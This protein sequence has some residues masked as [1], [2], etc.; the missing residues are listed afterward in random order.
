MA[1]SAWTRHWFGDAALAEAASRQRIRY[2]AQLVPG[3]RHDHGELLALYHEI[4]RLADAG[5]CATITAAL[6]GFK[7]RFDMHV[8]NE[9]LHFYCYLEER[10]GRQAGALAQLKEARA[11]MNAIG[12]AVV[13]F[14]HKYDRSGVRPSNVAQ[15]LEDL[16]AVGRQLRQRIEREEKELYPLYEP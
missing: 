2:S 7:S 10:L 4:E 15:F 8:L 9:N 14:V 16:R 5:R 12:R 3:L 6:A 11:E 1:A 13:Q